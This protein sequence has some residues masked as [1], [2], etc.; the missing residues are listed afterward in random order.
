VVGRT[1]TIQFTWNELILHFGGGREERVGGIRPTTVGD[2]DRTTDPA[3]PKWY[4]DTL[5]NDSSPC[6]VDTLGA[7]GKAFFDEPGKH[8]GDLADR[9]AELIRRGV[10][11]V[12][13]TLHFSTYLCCCPGKR[14]LARID[15]ERA[16][17]WMLDPSF[18]D[19]E[20]NVVVGGTSGPETSQMADEHKTALKK[21]FPK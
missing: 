18:P 1:L 8:F 17:Y 19:L 20:G 3:K 11:Y 21:R 2:L 6:K 10:M 14:A 9:A 16:F 5:L 15:W 4:L 7:F 12:T 13:E